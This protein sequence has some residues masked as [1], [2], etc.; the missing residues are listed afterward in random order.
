MKTISSFKLS[1]Y[2]TLAN[3]FETRTH[4]FAAL[5]LFSGCNH[6]RVYDSSPLL[7]FASE[8]SQSFKPPLWNSPLSY[9]VRRGAPACI[10]PFSLEILHTSIKRRRNAAPRVPATRRTFQLGNLQLQV[11]PVLAAENKSR[12][13]SFTSFCYIRINN[14]QKHTYTQQLSNISRLFYVLFNRSEHFVINVIE[15]AKKMTSQRNADL[16]GH[17]W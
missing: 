1:Q 11:D 10:H 6:D 4:L 16:I 2:I 8:R 15:G 17:F 12:K 5:I 9:F 13:S 3:H 7:H 14:H